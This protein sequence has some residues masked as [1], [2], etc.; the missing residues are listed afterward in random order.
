MGADEDTVIRILIVDGRAVVRGGL[1]Q[2]V[3]RLIAHGYKLVE[4]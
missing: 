1:R 2:G 3:R 4:I